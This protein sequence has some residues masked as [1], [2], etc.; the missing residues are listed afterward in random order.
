MSYGGMGSKISA[1]FPAG[2]SSFPVASVDSP[3]QTNINK[4]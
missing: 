4:P 2:T 3:L 1:E